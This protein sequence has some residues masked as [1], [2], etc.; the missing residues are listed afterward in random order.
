MLDG[1]YTRLGSDMSKRNIQ[2]LFAVASFIAA[3]ILQ[4]YGIDAQLLAAGASAIFGALAGYNTLNPNLS[5]SDYEEKN[6]VTE[7]YHCGLENC[8][9]DPD[10]C[11]QLGELDV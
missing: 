2:I 8:C 7:R 9:G 10:N 6:L 4:A 5:S 3:A 1:L 11:K